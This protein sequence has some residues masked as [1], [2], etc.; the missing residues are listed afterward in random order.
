MLLILTMRHQLSLHVR[1]LLVVERHASFTSLRVITQLAHD[2]VPPEAIA[3]AAATLNDDATA[4]L[5]REKTQMALGLVEILAKA[6]EGPGASISPAGR[7]ALAALR[8]IQPM[9][10]KPMP[11]ELVEAVSSL[12]K[13]EQAT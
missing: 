7:S 11:P 5:A 8:Q 1:E 10:A 2:G 12:R 13:H 3:K 6:V 9:Q 4:K